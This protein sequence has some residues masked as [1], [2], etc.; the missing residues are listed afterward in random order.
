[1]A[2]DNDAGRGDGRAT[3][4]SES[5]SDAS[6]GQSERGDTEELVRRV[7]GVARQAVEVGVGLG[8][9]GLLRFRSERPRLEAELEKMGLPQ[10]AGLSR[11]AGELLD[12]GV[13][14]LMGQSG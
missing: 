6:P 13:A 9:L 2:E 8:V 5:P 4:S 11:K 3:G 1:M 7:A 14:L 12:R 10:V